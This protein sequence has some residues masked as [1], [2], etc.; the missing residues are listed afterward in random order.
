M[1]KKSIVQLRN[2][3]RVAFGAIGKGSENILMTDDVINIDD[4]GIRIDATVLKGKKVWRVHHIFQA[5]SSADDMS[6]EVSMY[7]FDE[8]FGSEVELARR[9]SV[10]AA[11]KYI[12]IALDESMS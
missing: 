1:N 8:P 3:L 9:V 11:E 10:Y 12:E 2:Y 7:L 4:L 5:H 6:R